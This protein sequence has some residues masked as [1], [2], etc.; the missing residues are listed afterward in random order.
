LPRPRVSLRATVLTLLIV[1]EKRRR[2]GRIGRLLDRYW[3][4]LLSVRW[5][6][7]LARVGPGQRA[8]PVPVRRRGRLAV[9]RVVRRRV[10]VPR[11]RG[12]RGRHGGDRNRGGRERVVGAQG[13]TRVAAAGSTVGTGHGGTAAVGIAHAAAI[14]REQGALAAGGRLKK[15]LVVPQ[16]VRRA[17]DATGVDR[18]GGRGRGGERRRRARRGRRV[19]ARVLGEVE[20]GA[21][22]A[23]AER[24]LVVGARRGLGG[25]ERAEPDARRLVRVPDLGG[26]LAPRPLAHPAVPPPRRLGTLLTGQRSCRLV[27]L[28]GRRARALGVRTQLRPCAIYIYPPARTHAR[29]R[30]E[31]LRCICNKARKKKIKRKGKSGDDRATSAIGFEHLVTG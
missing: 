9:L 5:R 6:R 14:E 10:V 8:L 20:L 18:W 7:V 13:T 25:L 11:S 2:E 24:G 16:V 19:E 23:E 28:H 15:H 26:P 3:L 29:T 27:L 30:G 21:A 4:L 31:R 1:T 22:A 17:L 12:S